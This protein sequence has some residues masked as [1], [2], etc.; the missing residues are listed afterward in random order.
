MEPNYLPIERRTIDTQYK[1]C[2]RRIKEEGVLVKHP[3]QTEGRFTLLTLPPMIYKFSNGFPILTERKIGFWRKPIQELFAFING[4]RDAKVLTEEWGVNWWMEKWAT[5]EK[6]AEFGLKPY[7]MGSGSYGAALH[8]Y[9]HVEQENGFWHSKPFNQYEHLV[10]QIRQ[11]PSLATHKVTTWIPSYCLAHNEH[12]RQVVVAPCHGDVEVTIIGDKLT[13]RMDQRSDDFPIGHPS[14]MIQY[15]A[16]TLAI[17]H[18]TGY[19]PYMFIHAPHNAQIYER[20]LNNVDE[21][22]KRQSHVFPTMQ[23]TEEGKRITNIFDFRAKHFELSEYTAEP[24][25][26]LRDAVI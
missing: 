6:C 11:K 13:L 12:R 19:E 26:T 16:L 7:D 2:L 18:V 23:L 8:N 9:P 1:D 24:A 22:L 3:F 25:M 4:V 21:L 10:Q 14:N 20:H 5:P 17:A 15:A